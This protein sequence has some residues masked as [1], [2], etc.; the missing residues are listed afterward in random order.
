[1]L[2]RAQN[3]IDKRHTIILKLHE[4]SSQIIQDFKNVELQKKSRFYEIKKVD[5]MKFFYNL[6]LEFEVQNLQFE[7]EQV[8]SRILES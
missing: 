7:I 1:M 2:G 5:F 6:D 3:E 8:E 4:N